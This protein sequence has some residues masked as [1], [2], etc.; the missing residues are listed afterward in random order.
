MAEEGKVSAFRPCR[1]VNRPVSRLRPWAVPIAVL[2]AVEGL[3]VLAD[4]HWSFRARLLSAFEVATGASRLREEKWS[5]PERVFSADFRPAHVVRFRMPGSRNPIGETIEPG[6]LPPGRRV[7]VLGESAAFGVGSRSEETFAALL[8]EELKAKGTRV[9][10]AGQVGADAWQVLEAGAQILDRY[11]PSV[12]VIFTGNNLW[13]DW[14]PPQQRRWNPWGIQVLS[15]LATS[16]AIAGLEFVS[17]RLILSYTPRRWRVEQLAR[18]DS[19]LRG[20]DGFLDHQEMIGSRY[21]LTHPLEETAEF[22]AGDWEPV[23]RLHLERLRTSLT[24]LVERARERG[25]HVI[26]VTM[27]FLYRL[28]P[29]WKHPQPEAFDPV[30]RQEV[31]K[32]L[33]EAGRLVEARDCMSALPMVERALALDPLPPLLHY[34]RAQCLEQMGKFDEA[35]ASYA[36]SRERMIGNLGSRLS[37]NEVIRGV[38]A[39]FQVPLVDAVQVFDEHDRAHERRFDEPL[40][41]DDCHPSALGHRLLARAI[42]PLL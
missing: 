40:I 29:A 14:A 15:L 31:R 25:T 28:S 36:Q 39:R 16:R 7:I 22:G 35:R 21:A 5:E 13:I 37:I 19:T 30:H 10:N 34:L 32:L 9:F 23:K 2:I 33:R 26:L 4:R 12:L 11:A 17:L 18:A 41:L 6:A 27:P 1:A 24:M 8:D 20:E 38:A 42:A 3:A